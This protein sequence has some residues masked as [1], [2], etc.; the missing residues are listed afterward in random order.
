MKNLLAILF[1]LLISSTSHASTKT[2]NTPKKQEDIQP[3]ADSIIAKDY[4]A[5]IFAARNSD[6]ET[7]SKSLSEALLNNPHNLLLL[8]DTYKYMLLAGN[9]EEAKKFAEIYVQTDKNSPP[10][11]LLLAVY[12]ASKSN[13]AKA[14]EILTHVKTTPDKN[15]TIA[16]EQLLMPFIKMWVI[17]GQG[18]YDLALNILDPNNASKLI[19]GT[20]VSLQKA[21]LYSMSGNNEQAE[22]IFANLAMEKGTIPYHLAKSIAS[23]YE[24][25]GK[26]EDA[27]KIYKKYRAQHPT[28]SYF[29]HAEL[30]IKNKTTTGLYIA[31]PKDGLAEVMKEA[32]RLLFSSQLYGEGLVYLRL[33]LILRP[34]DEESMILM[35]NYHEALQNWQQAIDIYSKINV[36]SDLYYTGQINLAENLYRINKK[37]DAK[38]IL[39]NMAEEIQGKYIPLIILADLLRQDSDYKGAIKVYSDVLKNIDP[40]SPESWSVFFARGICYERLKEWKKSEADLL[41]ALELKPGQPEVA[42][43]LAYSWI[44]NNKNI[45]KARAMLL[46]AAS[47]RP[48]NAQILDSAG[49]AL[50]KSS[51]FTTAALFLE[52]ATE[53]SPQDAVMNDHLGDI[54]WMLNRRYEARYQWER[55]IKYGPAESSTKEELLR[56]IE[57]G[58]ED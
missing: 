26:W 40:K 39:R 38:K 9:Y 14:S 19:S 46:K 20:F 27:E 2:T 56:K 8:Q 10:A 53:F 17:A 43:Y 30:R 23:F 33:A 12:E 37:S 15:S 3:Q 5:G 6:Y 45:E 13:Y 50:Y 35:A 58:L 32:A 48:D 22:K 52:K 4:L 54:Y 51:D 31:N 16:V 36:D 18:K 7:A 1:L 25:I 34:D 44:E 21:L 57:K 29:E 55:A 42:N 47:L 49:W 41:T 11:L 24:S 28:S